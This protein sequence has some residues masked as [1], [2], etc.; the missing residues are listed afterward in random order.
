VTD[1]LEE[2]MNKSVVA[3]V[4]EAWRIVVRTIESVVNMNVTSLDLQV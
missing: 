1:I 2:A 3:V 4:G